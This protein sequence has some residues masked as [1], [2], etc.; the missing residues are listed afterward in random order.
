[1]SQDPGSGPRVAEVLDLLDAWY[2]PRLAESWDVVGLTVGS[3]AAPVNRIRLAVEPTAAVVAEAARAGADLLITH[4]PLLLR[5]IDR[6]RFDTPKGDL[7]QALVRHRITLV[8]AHTNADAAT[9]GVVDCLADALG[10]LDRRPLVP[11]A[12]T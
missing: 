3:P 4:H 1:M 9:G 10:L 2:P 5:G 11:A 7:I 8:V 6:V 12:G